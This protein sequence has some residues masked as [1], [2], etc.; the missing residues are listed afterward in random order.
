M[1][2]VRDVWY[3]SERQEQ[4]NDLHKEKETSIL[5]SH[6]EYHQRALDRHVLEQTRVLRYK[7][8]ASELD[9]TVAAVQRRIATLH[10]SFDAPL[11]RRYRQQGILYMMA[12]MH[13]RQ[14]WRNPYY[15]GKVGCRVSSAA[16]TPSTISALVAKHVENNELSVPYFCTADVPMQ[17]VEVDVGP[18]VVIPQ[19]YSFASH[20]PIAAGSFPRSWTLEGSVD[21]EEWAV[22]ARHTDDKSFSKH[23]PY[24]VW[25]L[26]HGVSCEETV[27]RAVGGVTYYRYFRVGATGVNSCGTH[28]FQ[29]ACF[30]IYGR[31]LCL[32]SEYIEGQEHTPAPLKER[33]PPS[34]EGMAPLPPEPEA[35][36][37]TK[38][39]KKTRR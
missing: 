5:A 21:R 25:T 11:E 39:M 8:V 14:A 30:E 16:P 1:L 13:G 23:S 38:N 19:A 20:H 37:K 6:Q 24:A 7:I 18:C 2:K 29:I 27:L 10:E 17:W 4:L 32:D 28:E 35:E 33:C 36:K 31:V 34:T 3:S 9:H 12:S 26:P 22:L 15:D